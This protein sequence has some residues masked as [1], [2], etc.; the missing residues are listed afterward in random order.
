M[1]R[2]KQAIK[3]FGEVLL[4]ILSFG[5]MGLVV[6]C[7]ETHWW[8]YASTLIPVATVYFLATKSAVKQE[9]PKVTVTP[10]FVTFDGKIAHA[11]LSAILFQRQRLTTS[12]RTGTI[13]SNLLQKWAIATKWKQAVL[14]FHCSPQIWV[15]P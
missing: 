3:E 2:T 13:V 10:K 14:C 15:I 8:A 7:F 6:K 5:V 9:K 4:G 12:T 1:Y 11:Q